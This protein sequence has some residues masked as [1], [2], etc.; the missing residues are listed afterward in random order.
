MKLIHS[1]YLLLLLALL[2]SS[3]GFLV[4]AESA[5]AASEISEE[6]FSIIESEE[7]LS[8]IQLPAQKNSKI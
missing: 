7:I 3:S 5:T 8:N 6:Q 1:K 2:F 4:F